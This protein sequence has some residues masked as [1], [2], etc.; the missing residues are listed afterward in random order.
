[1]RPSAAFGLRGCV[2]LVGTAPRPDGV[3][4]QTGKRWSVGLDRAA[5]P[6]V[7][8]S[9]V[10]LGRSPPLFRASVSSSVK[11][12]VVFG[13]GSLRKQLPGK[14][15]RTAVFYPGSDPRKRRRGHRQRD[16]RGRPVGA[17]RSVPPGSGELRPS[18]AVGQGASGTAPAAGPFDL[19]LTPAEG[20]QG[21]E[22]APQGS[23]EGR[24]VP[25]VGAHVRAP[26]PG[27]SSG[28]SFARLERPSA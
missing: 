4:K 26:A 7:L 12:E 8:T 15:L 1:M 17:W 9:R 2:C 3:V 13:V 16:R 24:Q 27:T 28:G 23:Q 20:A 5:L 19:P 6:P 10:A 22:T 11:W 21:P 14:S 25:G 18:T